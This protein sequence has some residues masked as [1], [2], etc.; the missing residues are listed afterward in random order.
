VPTAACWS[1][2]S[3]KS[4]PTHLRVC[5]LQLGIKQKIPT[6]FVC[7]CVC[8]RER[9]REREDVCMCVCVRLCCILAPHKIVPTDFV[10]ACVC[11]YVCLCRS[12]STLQSEILCVCVCMYVCMYARGCIA[13]VT[14]L[15][16]DFGLSVLQKHL[17]K[18]AS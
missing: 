14:W 8:V 5:V 7:V 1:L 18:T 2:A 13:K 11:V 4:C 16:T 12:L 10:C 17:F 9:E 6:T 3:R 15:K